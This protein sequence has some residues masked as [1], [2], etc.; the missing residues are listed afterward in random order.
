MPHKLGADEAKLR[1]EQLI[2]ETR[3]KFGTHV[4]ELRENWNGN[5]GTFSFR[6]MGFSV[7]GNLLVEPNVAHLEI[8]LPFAALPFK[9]RLENEISTRAKQLLA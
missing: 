6:A 5:H 9:G 3:A 7:S 1:I 4:S 2:S 8:H